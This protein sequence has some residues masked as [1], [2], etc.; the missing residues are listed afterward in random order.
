MSAVTKNRQSFETIQKMVEKAFGE[1][2][3]AEDKVK[4]LEGGYCNIV[5]EI[6][7]DQERQYIL[8]IAP[9]SNVLMMRYEKD[10]LKTE[11]TILKLMEDMTDI[12][13]PKVL[14]CDDS[15][16]VCNSPYFFMTKVEGECYQ[17]I[18]DRL[19]SEENLRIR[20]ELG[21]YNKAMN[22]LTGTC[23]GIPGIEETMTN[24][25]RTSMLRLFRMVL[26]DGIRAGSNL[27]SITY[28][29]MWGIVCSRSGVFDEV[30]TP[31]LI[32]WDLWEGNVFIKDKK[33]SG[34]IDF[35]RALYGDY[36]MEY[37]FAGVDKPNDSFE[38]GYGKSRYTKS[39][40]VR[41]SLYRIY[42]YLIMM[43]ECD[44]R[45]YDDNWQYKWS[46]DMLRKE[47]EYLDGLD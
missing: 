3:V 45:K 31:Q 20:M 35:E 38:K 12:P 7:L 40:L 22:D 8:K 18:K 39:E 34:I 14:Y 25:W 11:V 30:V 41:R 33:I 47:L 43:I 46:A 4:E 24:S 42:R 6:I 26:D 10:L 21:K 27:L 15:C 29:G 16:K 5:Y 19:T 1:V 28:D 32:H 44:Y 13:V 2:I 23:F 17:E 9:A 36:L 37:E